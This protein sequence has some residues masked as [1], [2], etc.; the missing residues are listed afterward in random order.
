[1]QDQT[2]QPPHAHRLRTGRHSCTGQIYLITTVTRDR[3]PLFSDLYLGRAVVQALRDARLSTRSLAF[4]IMPDHLHWLMQLREGYDL[5]DVVHFVK[6]DS[7]RMVNRL[8]R[9][10]GSVWQKGF[11][12]RA[13]RREE[14]LQVHARYIVNNPVRAG[15][16][17]SPLRYSLWDSVWV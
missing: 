7:A 6:S 3:D 14:L 10:S 1:M 13:L 12:D 17:D 11:H 4:V 2:H 8:R 5:S 15:I 16:V 9:G